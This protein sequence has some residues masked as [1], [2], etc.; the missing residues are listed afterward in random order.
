MATSHDSLAKVPSYV[1][2]FSLH[3]EPRKSY[4]GSPPPLSSHN[5]ALVWQLLLST[6]QRDLVKGPLLGTR[7]AISV[8]G[9]DGQDTWESFQRLPIGLHCNSP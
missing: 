7:A 6:N 2:C 8:V 3:R 9:A 5:R 1:V 4:R